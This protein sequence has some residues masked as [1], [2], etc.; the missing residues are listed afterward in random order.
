M[1]DYSVPVLVPF[2][3]PESDYAT[4]STLSDYS[5]YDF[6]LRESDFSHICTESDYIYA[7]N[8]QS[9]KS[10]IIITADICVHIALLI[11]CINIYN[12][13]KG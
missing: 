3:V 13:L 8:R 5:D 7:S 1:S 11:T 4:E 12:C 2:P 10:W 6:G 9:G